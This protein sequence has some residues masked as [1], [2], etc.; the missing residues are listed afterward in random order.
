MR[1][2]WL[3]NPTEGQRTPCPHPSEWLLLWRA[4]L[5]WPGLWTPHK[6]LG[7]WP[8][9]LPGSLLPP[10]PTC[11][12]G[13]TRGP[14][15]RPLL[16]PC[17]DRWMT[18]WGRSLETEV[19]GA[20]DR[21]CLGGK[22]G[23][24]AADLLQSTGLTCNSSCKGCLPLTE[25]TEPPVVLETHLP[26]KLNGDAPGIHTPAPVGASV[27][28]SK[29]VLGPLG[30]WACSLAQRTFRKWVGDLGWVRGPTG[31]TRDG[32]GPGLGVTPPL[33]RP[34]RCLGRARSAWRQQLTQSRCLGVPAQP[35]GVGTPDGDLTPSGNQDSTSTLL[36]WRENVGSRLTERPPQPGSLHAGFLSDGALRSRSPSGAISLSGADHFV[37]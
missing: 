4:L 15:T 31:P 25:L 14:C 28:E 34:A 22:C 9:T 35:V 32:P 16:F 37:C 6:P 10:L 13:S 2:V 30:D 11:M 18:R 36:P 1:G 26:P 19:A 17:S 23:L 21:H 27:L 29:V 3:P 5:T 20:G 7:R 24:W 8:C 12:C 33:T